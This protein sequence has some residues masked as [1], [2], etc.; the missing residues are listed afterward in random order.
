MLSNYAIIRAADGWNH[1]EAMIRL[2]G[3]DPFNDIHTPGSNYFLDGGIIDGN[4][5]A[6]GVSIDSGRETVVR[7]TSI[8]NTTVGLH[9][10]HGANSGSSDCDIHDVNIVGNRTAESVGVLVVGFDNTLT[11]MR[12]GGVH[13]GV[14]LKS[15]GNSMRNLHPLYY[16]SI[17]TYATSCGFI[18][19]GG[20]NWYD[21]CYSDQFATGFYTTGGSSLYNNCFAYWYNNRGEKHVVFR[22]KGRFNARV[23]NMNAGISKGNAAKENKILEATE[24]GGNGIFFNLTVTDPN[25]LTD[26]SHERYMTR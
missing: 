21:F 22:S 17:E 12:I 15:S 26:H 20:N 3:K 14:W 9:I 25:C 13:V 7:N 19:E 10:K 4:M 23:M 18:D 6:K 8:K 11:N 16:N 24:S 5:V 1:E 2:G